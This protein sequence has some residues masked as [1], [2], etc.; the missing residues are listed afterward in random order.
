MSLKCCRPG[1]KVDDHIENCTPSATYK[2]HFLI[3]CSL[4]MH[5]TEC[6]LHAIERNTALHEAGAQ[7]VQLKFSFTK[8]PS[9]KTTLIDV[10]FRL[11][12]KSI[13]EI[14]WGEE[15]KIELPTCRVPRA[16]QSLSRS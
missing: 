11:Y 4:K 14:G 8:S 2:L 6:P 9:K 15:N 3:W 1:S 10:L 12:D 7:T 5:S 16:S 13:S